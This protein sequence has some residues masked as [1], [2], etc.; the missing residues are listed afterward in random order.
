M[1][2]K[3]GYISGLDNKTTYESGME[4][5]YP[6]GAKALTLSTTK[7]CRAV[8]S[9]NG[10][11]SGWIL[12]TDILNYPNIAGNTGTTGFETDEFNNGFIRILSGNKKSTVYKITN[13]TGS[14]LSFDDTSGIISGDKF[15]VVTGACT[16]EF[17]DGRNPTRRDFKRLIMNTAIRYPYYGG[18]LVIPQGWQP[19]DFRVESELTDTR[20]A[21]RLELMLNHILDYKG[22]DGLYSIGKLNNNP[23]GFAPMV[24]ETN[25]INGQSY[26]QFQHLVNMVDY[27]IIKDAKKSSDF[28][29]VSIHFSGYNTPIYRGV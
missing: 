16:F 9:V 13:T 17:P 8:G 10:V 3:I 20:D 22:F 12:C 15:E 6:F 1:T 21:N 5:Y 2:W 27:S 7:M 14:S 4:E 23:H 11:Y 18:G 26:A 24:L 25:Q 19:D 28:Y 29:N